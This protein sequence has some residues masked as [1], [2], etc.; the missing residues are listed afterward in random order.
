[1]PDSGGLPLPS[2]VLSPFLSNPLCRLFLLPFSNSASLHVVI[3]YS[4]KREEEDEGGLSPNDLS[5]RLPSHYLETAAEES[6]CLLKPTYKVPGK[7]PD[8]SVWIT[9][10]SHLANSHGQGAGYLIPLAYVICLE[11]QPGRKPPWIT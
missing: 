4:V 6:F 8:W 9:C 11:Q 3:H 2:T 5:S 10:L 7:A 1:M